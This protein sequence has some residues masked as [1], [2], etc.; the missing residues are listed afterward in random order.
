MR[1]R[2]ELYG[3][4]AGECGASEAFVEVPTGATLA[5]VADALVLLYPSVSWLRSICRPALNLDYAGWDDPV[6]EGDEICFI[7]PVS[8]GDE[9]AVLAAIRN[10]PLDPAEALNWVQ[11]PELG[12]VVLFSGNVRSVNRGRDVL[13]IDYEA[14]RPMAERELRRI[15]EEA[16]AQWPGRIALIHRT[17]RLAAGESSVLVAAACP[18]RAAAFE[19]CRFAI[20]TLKERVPI[21]KREA[22]SGGEVWIEGEQH[23]PAAPGGQP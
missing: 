2:I 19:A 12:G 4:L 16:V 18:H 13:H 17:G 5:Q 1:I 21:W 22:W 8:G 20:D 10:E 15:G 11:R 9:E 6:Q 14:Y 23:I 3:R 7:P